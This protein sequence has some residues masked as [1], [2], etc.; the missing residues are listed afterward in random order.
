MRIRPSNLAFL[1]VALAVAPGASGAPAIP[2]DRTLVLLEL[3]GGL[4]GLQAVIPYKDPAYQALRPRLA[5]KPDSV[6]DL[7]GTIGLHPA[8]AP[9]LP[10]W[11]AGELAVVLGVGYPQP[12][13]SHFRSIDIWDSGSGSGQVLTDGWVAAA[14]AKASRPAGLFADGVVIGDIR[15]G[16]LNGPELKVIAI[17]DPSQFVGQAGTMQ[18]M[19]CECDGDEIPALTHLLDVQNQTTLA[20]TTLAQVLPH[21]P[22]PAGSFPQTSLG[23]QL[24]TAAILLEAGLHIPV[25]KLTLSGFDLHVGEAAR[26]QALLDQ[27][28]SAVAAFR[29]EL[30]GRK[31]WDRV[32]IMTYSEFGRRAQENANGGTDHGTAEPVLVLGGSV[33]GGLYGTQPSL[34][35]LD[36]GNLRFT[37]D[38]RSLY[39]TIA[40]RWWGLPTSFLS[41][42]P[43][44]LVPF[45][46]AASDAPL[47]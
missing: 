44:P 29:T 28:A 3:R 14:F 2:A 23:R 26:Q 7:N 45:L 21:A 12:D 35:N 8:L 46:S 4:D 9:L 13:L 36:N 16:P 6:L 27:L 24:R 25:L 10:A 41:G 40:S 32:L 38:Y 43:Y 11:K 15:A 37:T 18:D 39:A 33:K 47:P 34:A 30:T 42:G 20:A 17:D 31:I 5:L 19:N 22:V 1:V